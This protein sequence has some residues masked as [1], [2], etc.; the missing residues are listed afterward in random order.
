MTNYLNLIYLGENSY[1]VAA[2]A[3]TYFGQPVSKLTVAQDAV[4]AAIIQA[5]STYPLPQ[6]RTELKARW[7]YVL[8]QMVGQGHHPGAGRHDDVPQAADRHH[9]YTPPV[10]R[11]AGR[12]TPASPWAPYLMTQVYNELTAGARAATACRRSSSRPAA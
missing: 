3:Q 10:R 9:A 12:S 8:Q 4:I 6:N 11:R 2:A 5:P 1:G 7:Q